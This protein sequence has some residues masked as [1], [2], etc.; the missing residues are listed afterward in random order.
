MIAVA[1]DWVPAISLVIMWVVLWVDS[2]AATNC[3]ATASEP[4]KMYVGFSHEFSVVTA[5]WSTSYLQKAMALF[6]NNQ[7]RAVAAARAPSH[8]LWLLGRQ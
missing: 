6:P 3:F 2:V 1:V 8:A 7:A 4:K 5:V